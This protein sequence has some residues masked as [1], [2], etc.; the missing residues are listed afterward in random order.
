MKIFMTIVR[1]ALALIAAVVLFV[2][3]FWVQSPSGTTIDPTG[4]LIDAV[5]A[6]VLIGMVVWMWIDRKNLA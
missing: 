3:P 1:V 4:A 5:A 2:E 6:I